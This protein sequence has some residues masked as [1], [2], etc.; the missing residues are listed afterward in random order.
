MRLIRKNGFSLLGNIHR[1]DSQPMENVMAFDEF[2]FS[3]FRG[4]GAW[5]YDERW[6]KWSTN[7]A[8]CLI[9]KSKWA[10]ILSV[11]SVGQVEVQWYY[12]HRK[13]RQLTIGLNNQQFF[14]LMARA[15]SQKTMAGFIGLTLSVSGSMWHHFIFYLFFYTWFGQ[16]RVQS[17]TLLRIFGMCCRSLY[18][19]VLL[20]ICSC[21][22]NPGE[23]LCKTG[24][25]LIETM[26]WCT[27]VVIKAKHGPI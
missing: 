23:K 18:T 21:V 25:K 11:A 3:L 14:P 17:F 13:W 2:T 22:H 9:Y 10:T 16:H 8:C 6:M 7:H 27:C 20:I 24:R 4:M 26:P 1:P 19:T 15:S 5:R 12:V